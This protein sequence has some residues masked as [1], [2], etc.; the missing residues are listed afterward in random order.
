MDKKT[1][2]VIATHNGAHHADDVFGVAILQ[3]LHA[4]ATLVRTRDP[5][6][7]AKADF[8]VDVGGVWDPAA[9]RFD[10][11][12]K[13]FDGKRPSGVV[14]A[15]AGLVWQAHGKT[16][17][18]AYM[19]N[20]SA[21]H[22]TQVHQ[23][24]DDELVQHLDMADTGAAVGA[25][26]YF[27]LSALLSAFNTSRTEEQN[28]RKFAGDSKEFAQSLLARAKQDQ[29]QEAVRFVQALVVR[30]M[31]Q[32]GDELMGADTVRNAQLVA[33][34]QILVLPESGL[35][36]EKVVCLEM[37]NVLFVVYPDSTDSQFQV[38]TVPVEPQSFKAR[39]DLPVAWA[40]LRDKGLAEV[41]GVADAVFCHNG[42]FIGG[43]GSQAGAVKMAELALVAN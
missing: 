10:H 22:V 19:E 27:G 20:L 3:L 1:P 35:S 39:K 16:L 15:S 25:P 43:A 12:Q 31:E 40:G 13:G 29:F 5:E 30:L 42:R 8:A 21:E 17:I 23:L 32:F 26:G 24:I 33:E 41:C 9:G 11:H 6:I 14:Y 36:W 2:V 4:D 18:A 37:P 34:G 7:I 38:R 28:V